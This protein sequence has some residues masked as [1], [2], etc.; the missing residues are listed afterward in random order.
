MKT[1]PKNKNRYFDSN[2]EDNSKTDDSQK[3]EVYTMK[4]T[5]RVLMKQKYRELNASK[6]K[7]SQ[8]NR[9]QGIKKP[10]NNKKSNKF[11]GKAPVDEIKL[12]QHSRGEGIGK[13]VK[14]PLHAVKLKKREQ[15]IS[16]AQDQ[17][18][19]ADILLTEEAGFVE[20]E[21][22][23]KTIEIT[24]NLI[25]DN[26]D[27][28]AATK[29]FDLH[30][31]FGPYRM[32]YSRNGRHLL[33]G[34]KKGHLAAFDWVTKKLHCEINVMESIHDI[35]QVV[36]NV[37][38]ETVNWLHVETMMAV[39]QKEW[40]YI[41]D[42]TGM[43]LHCVKR[44]DKILRMEFLPYH[45]LLAA[46][47]EFGFMTW[48][49]ISIGE[50]VGHYNNHLGRTSVMT[51]NPYNGTVCLGNSQGVVSLWSP[52]V[53]DPLAK[54]L[55]HKT[56]LTAIAVDNRGMYMA[57]SG[58]DRSLKIYDIRNLDGP[59]Q[60]YKL[61][62][63]PVDLTFS[64]KDMLAV[65][66]EDVVEV[67]NNCCTETVAKPYM[68]HRM[69]KNICN[70][71]FCPYEDVLG[72]GTSK[73]FT[74][75][76]IPGSGEPNFDALESNPFQTKKQRKEAEVKALLEKIPPELIT[77]NPFEV[78][79]VDVPTL[80]EN[81]EAKKKIRFVKPKKVDLTPRHKNKG[82]TNIARKKIIKDASRK[83]FIE[84]TIEAQKV[85]GIPEQPTK[86][87]QSFGV[88]DRFVS[89]PK[90]KSKK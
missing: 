82:K 36:N 9:Q 56:P 7:N 46:V 30:L 15:K 26:V 87:R 52:T 38:V 33:M 65:G 34:G 57:T 64:Q 69:S 79:E 75:I 2:A 77:L 18:A 72:I 61:R 70:F 37:C 45:F 85:L 80:K 58:V 27:I 3:E 51:Q 89:N 24:Q 55:C 14:H 44:M 90:R 71:K 76:I 20:V 13:G 83:K 54:I 67:Y 16:Y 6:R 11:P 62:C 86:P 22:G 17:A 81:L 32:K 63:A 41:Y 47:N 88:L 29:I 68:R 53:K 78:A 73:G 42:N 59:I 1:K 74:S 39:A 60:H 12:E 35:R 8:S 48:L 23:G 50:V 40:L 49:D 31:D 10:F 4:I 66:L 43:E 84:E 5:P 21:E 25:R 19:R 28:T